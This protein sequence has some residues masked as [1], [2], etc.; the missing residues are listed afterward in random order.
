[1]N[2]LWSRD[3]P[4]WRR[5]RAPGI[6]AFICFWL[7]I[8]LGVWQLYRLRW[9]EGILAQIHV[10][11]IS[12]PIALPAHPNRFQ[13]VIVAGTMGARARRFCMAMRCMTGR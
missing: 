6:A 10:A 1:M 11:E 12:P 5:L 7:L 9:K 13:K 8:G 4:R 2:P 3:N